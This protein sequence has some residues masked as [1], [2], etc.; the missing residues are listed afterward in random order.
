ML[1]S[2]T[3]REHEGRFYWKLKVWASGEGGGGVRKIKYLTGPPAVLWQ[4][5]TEGFR[6]KR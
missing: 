2:L 1:S 5:P 4:E 6:S 3:T